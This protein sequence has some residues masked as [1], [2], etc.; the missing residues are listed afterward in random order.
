MPSLEPGGAHRHEP[1]GDVARVLDHQHQV[2]CA[3]RGEH[4]AQLP[5]AVR[6]G[7]QLGDEQVAARP[8]ARSALRRC[9]R[10]AVSDTRSTCRSGPRPRPPRGC[11]TPAAL[12]SRRARR[13]RARWRPAGR[14]RCRPAR[15]ARASRS[16]SQ[17]EMRPSGCSRMSIGTSS[18]YRD[19]VVRAPALMS[20]KVC[21]GV[22]EPWIDDM[23]PNASSPGACARRS[24]A[25]GFASGFGPGQKTIAA[26]GP[27]LRLR[28]SR[29]PSG[30]QHHAAPERPV[31]LRI[32]VFAR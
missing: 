6:P 5:D 11:G 9:P 18:S 23:K 30:A 13:H 10:G 8:Q 15:H 20:R 19:V 2:L 4:V 25:G 3:A 16:A 31:G 21:S 12:R 22:Y 27:L 14:A 29:Q 17:D 28:R 26:R 24:I 1:P 32:F 7:R